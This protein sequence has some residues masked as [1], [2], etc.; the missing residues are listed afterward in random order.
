MSAYNVQEKKY[1]L[2]CVCMELKVFEVSSHSTT[3]DQTVVEN[4]WNM[5]PFI[6]FQVSRIQIVIKEK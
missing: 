2:A 6:T 3:Y 1:T 4:S 5:S